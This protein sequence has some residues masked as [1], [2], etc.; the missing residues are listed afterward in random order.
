M[1]RQKLLKIAGVSAGIVVAL[2]VGL[3]ILVKVLISPELVKKTVLP[4]ISAYLA[5]TGQ[6][7]RVAQDFCR[8][9]PPGQSG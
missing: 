5:G 2:L 1:N 4:K 9:Q 6:K 3:T 7:D 8:H